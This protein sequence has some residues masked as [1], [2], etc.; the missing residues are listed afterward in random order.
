MAVFAA[1]SEVLVRNYDHQLDADETIRNA[2]SRLGSVDYHLI[3]NNCEHFAAWCCTGRAVSGQ[4]RR[5]LLA[6][7]GTLATLVATQPMGI[8]IALLE[9]VS[10]SLYALARPGRYS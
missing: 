8:H 1:G 3:R 10:A 9:T 6:T 7:Q 4:V 2:E 5:W